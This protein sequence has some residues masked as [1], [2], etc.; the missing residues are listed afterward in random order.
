MYRKCQA[1][2]CL[3]KCYG[4]L[5]VASIPRAP[6]T[7]MFVHIPWLQP[8]IQNKPSSQDSKQSPQTPVCC[9]LDSTFALPTFAVASLCQTNFTTAPQQQ[10]PARNRFGEKKLCGCDVYL[11]CLRLAWHQRCLSGVSVRNPTKQSGTMLALT[12][13]VAVAVSC[14][15]LFIV[16]SVV[17]TIVWVR[18]RQEK[19]SMAMA[20]AR[21]GRYARGLQNFPAETVTELSPEE[22]ATLG[23]YGQ[24]PYGNPTEWALIESR[25][26]LLNHKVDAEMSPELPEK[27][28]SLRHSLSRSKSKRA[29]K[30]GLRRPPRLSSLATLGETSEKQPSE[31]RGSISKDDVSVSAVEGVMELPAETSP[32][33][34]P[35]REEGPPG[36]SSGSTNLQSTPTYSVFMNRDYPSSLFPVREDQEG[37]DPYRVRLRGGSIT[38]QTAG[39]MPDQPV[40]PPPPCAY[41]PNRF[42]LPRNDSSMRLSCLSLD[43]ADSSILDGVRSPMVVDSSNF[44][45]PALPP[46]PTFTPYSANDVGRG[47]S[48]S[49]SSLEGTFAFP[50]EFEGHRLEPDRTSP[51]RSM[52]ARTASHSMERVSPPPRRSES[53]SANPPR[54]FGSLGNTPVLYPSANNIP[55]HWNGINYNTALLPHFS[56][57]R[58]ASLNE[59]RQ[60]EASEPYF[61]SSDALASSDGP[62]RAPPPSV[63]KGGNGPRK[64]HKRQNCVRISIHPPITFGGAVFSPTVEEDPEELEG[65][66]NR[67]SEVSELSSTNMPSLPS[68]STVSNDDYNFQDRSRPPSYRRTSYNKNSPKK[69]KHARTEDTNNDRTLP[70]IDTDIPSRQ[71]SLSRTPSPDKSPPAWMTPIH[72][73][74]PTMRENQPAP[75][76]HRISA[77]KGPR[78]QPGKPA[79]NNVQRSSMPLGENTVG[80]PTSSPHQR[81][82]WEPQQ[83]KPSQ[84]LQRGDSNVTNQSS[85]PDRDAAEGLEVVSGPEPIRPLSPPSC[86]VSKTPSMRSG[87]IVT[88]WEDA[89]L[90]R[91]PT[92]F[93]ASSCPG[94]VIEL[95]G[96]L[97]PTTANNENDESTIARHKS[98]GGIKEDD[99]SVPRTCKQQ[100]TVT[101]PVKKTVGLGIGAATPGSLY[102]GDGFLKE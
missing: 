5:C 77:V 63:L 98:T 21:T 97:A 34:T 81:S 78:S 23:Q 15:V 8:G 46:C 100:E 43:T 51:R 2:W 10:L 33:Q 42:H 49:K 9:Q 19:L 41:P 57:M 80:S 96:D 16:C 64:G 18:I 58:R 56:Q 68:V 40:P 13:V 73:P 76:S 14:G 84:P 36:R 60:K 26:R 32:R 91:T 30:G 83:Q 79:G 25:E 75:G 74:S 3:A 35:D 89:K 59:R 54:K 101:T 102:D 82:S 66:E 87:N 1:L 44:N 37:F 47:F 38:T 11:K 29:S 20:N 90:E 55:A 65:S 4:L 71:A 22:G 28:R 50:P 53:L 6:P 88:I 45:S 93:S 86:G 99:K 39:A 12:T 61:S 72:E 70:E 17:G 27:A 94:E 85:L 52:T 92:K 69:R 48:M 62:L 67:R 7:V 95:Q 24:L 31:P